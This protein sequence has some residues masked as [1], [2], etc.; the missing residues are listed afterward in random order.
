MTNTVEHDL[1]SNSQ[2]DLE[3]VVRLS[4]SIA[5]DV[6]NACESSR[7]PSVLPFKLRPSQMTLPENQGAKVEH[8][9]SEKLEN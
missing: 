8:E 4:Q 7:D 9:N 3:R 2:T 5:A 6:L 1:P